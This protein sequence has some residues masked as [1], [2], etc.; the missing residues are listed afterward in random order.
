MIPFIENAF[1][2]GVSVETESEIFIRID[3]REGNLNLLV[4][5][6]IHRQSPEL[7]YEGM[8][9][10]N[11]IERMRLYYVNNFELSM[12]EESGFFYV[13]LKIRL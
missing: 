5:N 4:K 9:V 2:H 13:D 6:Q 12:V 1:K 7:E 11:T 8:G 3:C 10:Q